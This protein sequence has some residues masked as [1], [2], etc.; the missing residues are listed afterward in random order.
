MEVQILLYYLKVFSFLFLLLFYFFYVFFVKEISYNN[1][2]IYINKNQNYKEIIEQNLD[3]NKYNLLLYK[4]ALKILILNN[5]KI[6]YGK[7]KYLKNN[8]FINLVKTISYPSNYL[9]KLT[10]IEGS[11]KYDLNKKLNNNFLTYTDLEYSELIADTYFFNYGLTFNEFKKTLHKNLKNIKE[12]YKNH[13]LLERFN[14]KEILIIG[15]LLEKEGLDHIDKKKIYSVIIN[16]LN[17]NMKLQIDATVIYAITDGKGKLNRK[18]TYNDLKIKDEFNTYYIYGLPPEPISYVGLKTIELIFENYT[19][20][21]LFYFYNNL[22][23]KH[24]YS[25]NY[26]NHLIK[27]NE[28]RSKK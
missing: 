24:I 6:H 9:E 10:I 7:F 2:Y 20:N 18:L 5:V 4:I 12:K 19:S 26:E 28:Y 1:D 15:S 13:K 3:E 25:I 23:K 22:E 16:R 11:S 14:F 17:Q 21:F 27:L 8:N